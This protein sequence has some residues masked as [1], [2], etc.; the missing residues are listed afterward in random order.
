M[1]KI[2]CAAILLGTVYSLSAQEPAA[3]R[4]ATTASVNYSN[5]VPV[6]IRTNFQTANPTVTQVTWMPMNTDWW[7]ASYMNN[8]NRMTRVYYNTQPWYLEPGRDIN[9][10]VSLPVLN[11]YV[12]DD[13][14]ATAIN[15]YG[16]D[17]F[18]ITARKPDA[19]GMVAYHVTL[20]KNGVSEIVL[21]NDN[22]AY[23]D[24]NKTQPQHN[25]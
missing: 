25:Q 2:F 17:L 22:M 14:I 6:N 10:K 20:I 15:R 24:A 13:V 7:Y 21:M 9:F 23:N 16:N 5:Q 8:D 19:N 1:K 11:T 18:S 4:T 12:P 3:Y